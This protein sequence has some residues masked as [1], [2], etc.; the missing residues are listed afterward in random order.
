MT[1]AL[2]FLDPDKLLEAAGNSAHRRAQRANRA[3]QDVLKDRNREERAAAEKLTKRLTLLQNT[4]KAKLF[5]DTGS[6]TDFQRFSV[7]A[8]AADVDR[9]VTDA[10]QDVARDAKPA[11]DQMATLGDHAADEPMRAAQL[12]ITPALPGLD[13]SLVSAAFDNTIDLLTLPMRQFATDVK[14]SLRRVALAGDNKSDEIARL[15]D[16]IAGQGF[17]TAAYKAE[18][19]VRTELGRVFNQATYD[20]LLDLSKTFPFMRKGWRA[21]SDNRTRLG[22]RNAGKTYGRGYGVPLA[23]RFTIQ[24]HEERKGQIK[25]LGTVQLRFP[26]DPHA[27]PAGRLAAAATI[28]CRCNAFV[29]FDLADFAQFTAQQ[30]QLAMGGVLPPITA[31]PQP[32]PGHVPTAPPVLPKPKRTRV[33]KPQPATGHK[34]LLPTGPTEGPKV[35]AA[36][37]APKVR[38][39]ADLRTHGL[40]MVDSVHSDGELNPIPLVQKGGRAYGYFKFNYGSGGVELAISR[41]G[42]KA[43]PINTIIHETGHMLDTQAIPQQTGA[44]RGQYASQAATS[45]E[46]KAWKEATKASPSYQ[47]LRQWYDSDSAVQQPGMKFRGQ[48]V[49]QSPAGYEGDGNVPKG[50]KREHLRYLLSSEETFAR[51]Y[52]QYVTIRSGDVKGMAELRMMQKAA[53]YGAVRPEQGYNWNPMGTEPKPDTWDYPTVWADDEFEPIAKAFDA[54]F[55]KLGWRKS[56]NK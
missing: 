13:A 27:T 6:V 54:L 45:P 11:Y 17:D 7:T 49:V 20:R 23:D 40:G 25:L 5:S 52:A 56:S 10:T 38:A 41:G 16:Q 53:T 43:H 47:R 24:V 32:V 51:S 55:E 29:D 15:R 8:L 46:M 44:R 21:S 35:S 3:A 12:R 30:V 4:L 2:A 36:L 22:H 33:P 50:L 39:L 9:L 19:I 28:M 31:G 37:I 26:L 34:E 1:T 18:R 48:P 42:M 14:V